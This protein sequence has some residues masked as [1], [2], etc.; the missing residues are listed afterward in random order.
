MSCFEGF[1]SSMRTSYSD[2][3]CVFSGGVTGNVMRAV[4]EKQD[5]W[6]NNII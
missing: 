1:L 5:I 4:D 6:P 3:H 2:L